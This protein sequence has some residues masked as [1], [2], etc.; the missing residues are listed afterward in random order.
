MVLGSPWKPTPS[1][2]SHWGLGTLSWGPWNS[3]LYFYL[4]S[5]DGPPALKSRFNHESLIP[6]FPWQDD[7]Q[8]ILL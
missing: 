5:G 3:I 7:S 4:F 2:I 8:R 1:P 6:H